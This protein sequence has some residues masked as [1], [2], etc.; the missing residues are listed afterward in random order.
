VGKGG[1]V[2]FLDDS[3]KIDILSC[4]LH[5]IDCIVRSNDLWELWRTTFVYGE[6][7]VQDRHL[8]WE[9]LRHLKD[10]INKPWLML[11]DFN[12]SLWGFEHFSAQRR[13]ERQML[14]F[15]KPFPS[16]ICMTWASWD[17]RGRMTT[18]KKA[19]GKFVSD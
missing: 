18:C 7:R 17:Y 16:V 1:H 5:H 6:P 3:V 19:Q 13:S 11:G 4:G 15:R 14:D 9:L 8:M 2:L 12:E 10:N